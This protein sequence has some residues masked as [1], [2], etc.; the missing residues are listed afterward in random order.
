MFDWAWLDDAGEAL[1]DAG[2]QGVMCTPTAT[3]PAW[4]I[5]KHPEI[6][7]TGIDGHIRNFGSRRH[8]DHA[9]PI[10]REH[11][12]RIT[13]EVAG[14]YGQHPTVVGWQTDNKWGF[15][16]TTRS[17]G[18]ASAVAFR[19]WL[20]RK[21]GIPDALNDAW[22]NVF[23]S[24]D[25]TDW[26]QID[27]PFNMVTDR[28]PSHVLDFDRFASDAVRDFQAEQLAIIRELSPGRWVTHNYTMHF[29]E[30]DQYAN[31]ELLDFASWDSYPLGQVERSTMFEDEK[32]R[33]ARTGH[34]D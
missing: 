29:M 34:P 6:L 20:E 4:L 32:V 21:Y 17:Y 23:W 33:W 27:P 10:C 22:G 30:L 16:S 12:R 18:G 8:Y 19:E 7:P 3:P 26:G 13:R 24:Q 5:R 15:H 9:S 11:S 14:R 25:H 31:S 2:L 1:A 28:N